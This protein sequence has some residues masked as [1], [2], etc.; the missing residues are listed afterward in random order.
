MEIN[1]QIHRII[2]KNLRRKTRKETPM[3]YKIIS[4]SNLIWVR[5][6]VVHKYVSQTTYLHLRVNSVI[7]FK[8]K[9]KVN[10]QPSTNYGERIDQSQSV[11]VFG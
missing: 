6:M 7:L 4:I 11:V 3:F 10:E 1:K 9:G 8:K 2:K 5:K